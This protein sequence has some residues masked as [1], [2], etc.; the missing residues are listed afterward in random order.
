MTKKELITRSATFF[1]IVALASI[2]LEHKN[3]K[4]IKSI[5]LLINLAFSFVGLMK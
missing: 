2:A 4:M 1:V 5:T 3:T